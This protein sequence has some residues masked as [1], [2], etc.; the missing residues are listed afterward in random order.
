MRTPISRAGAP[1]CG[2]GIDD[3]ED[4]GIAADTDDQ[5]DDRGEG[6]SG[7]PPQATD[8]VPHVE[9]EVAGARPEGHGAAVILT[10]RAAN[11]Y[12]F[13]NRPDFANS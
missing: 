6:K 7:R 11:R 2:W 8:G 10:G 12:A 9:G 13:R 1:E 4:C 3:A 5:R